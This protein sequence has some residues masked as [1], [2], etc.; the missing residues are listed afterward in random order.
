MSTLT[1]KLVDPQ[2]KAGSVQYRSES[3]I[4]QIRP[5]GDDMALIART[6]RR[7][8]QAPIVYEERSLRVLAYPL[9]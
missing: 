7:V 9:R 3:A 8:L 4:P 6:L 2:N 5:E 1:P